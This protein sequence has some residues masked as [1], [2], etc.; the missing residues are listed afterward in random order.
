MPYGLELLLEELE[1]LPATVEDDDSLLLDSDE[2]DRF[3]VDEDEAEDGLEDDEFDELDVL[4]ATVEDDDEDDDIVLSL[5]EDSEELEDDCDEVEF[6]SV[7]DE[8]EDC[9]L[10]LSLL[11]LSLSTPVSD[12]H[13]AAP[14]L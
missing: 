14:V 4:P 13:T 5:L 10:L 6:A 3:T 11:L 12:V 8:D 1:V 9:E 2:V 7:E